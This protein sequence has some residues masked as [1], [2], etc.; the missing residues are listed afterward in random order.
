MSFLKK[1]GSILLKVSEYAIGVEH[2][3][4]ANSSTAAMLDK[5]VVTV[6]QLAALVVQIEAV[7]QKFNMAGP[8]KASALAPLIGNVIKTSDLMTG[9]KIKDAAL[10]DKGCAGIGG[11]L[12]DV[13][14]SFDDNVKTESVAA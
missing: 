6:T 5:G 3:M 13:L 10:F 7:G 14:N 2:L 9:R 12:A 8:D 11:A 1:L 4:P